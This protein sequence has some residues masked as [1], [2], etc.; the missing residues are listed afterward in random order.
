M[1]DNIK[2][3]LDLALMI[4][5]AYFFLR[6][7]FRGVIK[8]V[9]A[10]LGIFI[11]FWVASIYWG[12]VDP[13]LKPIFDLDSH[14]ATISF[15]MVFVVVYF[16]IGVISIFVDKIVKLAIS[17]IVSALLGSLVGVAKGILFCGVIMIVPQ[18]FIKP[19]DSLF[20][21]S[22]LWPHLE[23]VTKQ[24]K[25]WLPAAMRAA[26]EIT[27]KSANQNQNRPAAGNAPAPAMPLDQI[28]WPTI[29]NLLAN[30]SGEISPA[31]RQKLRNIKSGESLSQEDIK[32]FVTDHPG[33][34]GQAPIS[35]VGAGGS[36]NEAAPPSWPQPAE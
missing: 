3:G 8:E 15:I 31:W 9:V 30:R 34:F 22:Q 32:R 6:G 35:P 14:R 27:K 19:T 7:I 26:M 13:H 4:V 11:A 20:T 17:P 12:M 33:L 5:I 24:A 28:D 23:Q 16:I 29:Q 18:T 21:E 36:S 25:I 10:V 1:F 2:L